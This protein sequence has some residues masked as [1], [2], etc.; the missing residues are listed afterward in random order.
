MACSTIEEIYAIFDNATEEQLA[1]LETL[2]EEK[3]IALDEH[4][5][6]LEPE[7]LPPVGIES[8]PPV[9][10]EIIIPGEEI[11][12]MTDVAPFKDPVAGPIP[13]RPMRPMFS[14]PASQ[15]DDSLKLSKTATANG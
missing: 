15:E 9:P 3:L 14:V 2:S 10:S 1:A 4:I 5:T 12:N 8:E 6:A 11:V 7:P 13:M